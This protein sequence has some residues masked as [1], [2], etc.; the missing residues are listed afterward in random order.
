MV[1][2]NARVEPAHVIWDR[3]KEAKAIEPRGAQWVGLG[4]PAQRPRS[5][6]RPSFGRMGARCS[7]SAEWLRSISLG[8]ATLREA[9]FSHSHTFSNKTAEAVTSPPIGTPEIQH[10]AMSSC[11]TLIDAAAD[12]IALPPRR[13]DS[14]RC[15]AKYAVMVVCATAPRL[16]GR[17]TAPGANSGAPHAQIRRRRRLAG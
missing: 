12:R 4:P 14:T 13:A 9:L 17:A 2:S 3:G 15:R 5:G 16:G 11:C 10:Q 8:K 6:A 1:P 7:R